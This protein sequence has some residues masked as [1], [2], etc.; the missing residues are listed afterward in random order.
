MPATGPRARALPMNLLPNAAARPRQADAAATQK[1]NGLLG[2]GGA[3]GPLPGRGTN[4]AVGP[5][6]AP[7]DLAPAPVDIGSLALDTVNAALDAAA[8]TEVMPTEAAV[9]L[10]DGAALGPLNPAALADAVPMGDHAEDESP[11]AAAANDGGEAE[12]LFGG[13]LFDHG[14]VLPPLPPRPAPVEAKDHSGAPAV[15]PRP[16]TPV[17][18]RN[19]K[20]QQPELRRIEIPNRDTAT[21]RAGAPAFTVP[22]PWER[23]PPTGRAER[24]DAVAPATAASLHRAEAPGKAAAAP[25]L[26]S[27]HRPKT[28]EEMLPADVHVVSP[29]RAHLRIELEDGTRVQAQVRVEDR[30]VEVEFRGAPEHTQHLRTHAPELRD[31]LNHRGLELTRVDVSAD[32]GRDTMA[33]HDDPSRGARPEATWSFDGGGESAPASHGNADDAPRSTNSDNLLDLRL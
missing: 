10:A 18:E 23:R 11:A 13:L 19:D 14:A 8:L 32:T 7:A 2:A 1:W 29:K 21:A 28:M 5:M 17:R 24:T 16:E 6:D 33:R 27:I 4:V 26:E 9:A 30:K 20:S 15:D 22:R 12:P 31:A 25:A 3:L